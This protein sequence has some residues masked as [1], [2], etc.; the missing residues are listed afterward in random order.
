MTNSKKFVLLLLLSISV[1]TKPDTEEIIKKIGGIALVS[2]VAYGIYKF[3]SWLFTESNETIINRA[4]KELSKYFTS[5]GSAIAV[6]EAAYPIRQL[7]INSRL[8]LTTE[9]N[10]QLLY[11]LYPLTKII[12]SDSVNYIN[13]LDNTVRKLKKEREIVGKRINKLS[14]DKAPVFA[15]VILSDRSESKDATPGKRDDR[16]VYESSNNFFYRKLKEI[17]EKIDY[18]LISLEF[19]NILMKNHRSYFQLN[20]D[21]SKYLSIYKRELDIAASSGG[22]SLGYELKRCA[23][24]KFNRASYPYLIYEEKISS[25]TD[26]LSESIYRLAYN[27]PT[28]IQYSKQLLQNLRTVHEYVITD[29]D[30]HQEKIRR[31]NDLREKER[32]VIAQRE[33]A[34]KERE[35]KAREQQAQAAFQH[36]NILANQQP[37]KQTVNI[38]N[39]NR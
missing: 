11:N 9:V 15:S 13:E 20:D 25:D 29:P 17:H 26:K 33:A 21:Y 23:L 7:D 3:A 28:L 18:Q 31:E 19:L 38:N 34:A 30:F 37:N 6:V 32:I 35:A 2:A 1:S 14:L 12:Y 36:N 10:E 22:I 24:I 39:I 16:G 8:A 5:L 4:E 27:Y